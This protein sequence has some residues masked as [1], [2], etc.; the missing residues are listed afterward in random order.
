MTSHELQKDLCFPSAMGQYKLM[1]L[2]TLSLWEESGL[3]HLACN[4][5]VYLYPKYKLC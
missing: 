5:I 3:Q 2:A 1:L 4:S